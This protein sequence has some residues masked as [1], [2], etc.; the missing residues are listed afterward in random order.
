MTQR[1]RH[2]VGEA[3]EWSAGLSVSADGSGEVAHAGSIAVRLLADRNGL[4]KELSK[5]TARRSFVPVHDRACCGSGEEHG[6][7]GAGQRCPPKYRL[8]QS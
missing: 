5:A 8:T 1:E 3:C 6:Q 4:T 7:D 2:F